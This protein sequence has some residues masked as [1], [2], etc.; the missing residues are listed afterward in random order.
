MSATDRP[1]LPRDDPAGAPGTAAHDPAGVP[2]VDPTLDGRALQAALRRAIA[3]RGG[4]CWWEVDHAGRVVT[5][6]SPKEQGFFG[7]TLDE[8]LAWC[9]VWL[10]AKRTGHPEGLDWGP[11][12]GVWLFPV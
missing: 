1:V 3:T 11:E 8:A 6:H 7:R 10:M 12:L 4:A 5:R 9:L 2:R